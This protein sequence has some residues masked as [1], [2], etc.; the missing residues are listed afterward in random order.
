M[1]E[2]RRIMIDQK[3]G[4]SIA[5]ATVLGTA[6]FTAGN[7]MGKIDSLDRM[8]LPQRLAVIQAD[9]GQ[10]KQRLGI[11]LNPQA[12]VDQTFEELAATEIPPPH[13]PGTPR[14]AA[15]SVPECLR[16]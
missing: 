3:T 1:A 15:T 11:P 12:V 9:L 7:Y 2:P 13:R 16:K 6:L 10:I 5:V 14:R 4:L 8:N